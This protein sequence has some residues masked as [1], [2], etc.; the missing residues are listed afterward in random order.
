MAVD[1]SVSFAA[2]HRRTVL[3]YQTASVTRAKYASLHDYRAVL[4]SPVEMNLLYLGPSLRR[5]FLDEILSLAHEPFAKLKKEYSQVLRSRNALLKRISEG[6]AKPEMLDAWD[7]LFCAKAKEYAEYRFELLDHFKN[8]IDRINAS[9][10]GRNELSLAVSSKI[11]PMDIA[12]SIREYVKSH[13]EKDILV[14]HTCIGPHLDD[15]HFEV[16]SAEDV[17]TSDTY[18][19]RGENKSILLALKILSIEYIE[20]LTGAKS[21]LLL[22][23]MASELDS[24]HCVRFLQAFG[25]R[26]FILTGHMIPEEVLSFPGIKRMHLD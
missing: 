20:K 11:D 26:P 24:A 14:G 8:H 15:F 12:T 4:F 1:F 2:E 17:L 9:V 22:D 5:D 13:R 23:D 7:V 3:R 21:V 6:E 25:D 16:K 10:G 18:L 19:S